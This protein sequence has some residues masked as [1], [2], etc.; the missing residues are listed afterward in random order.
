MRNSTL[1]RTLL[2]LSLVQMAAVATLGSRVA[3]A[4]P[5]VLP[6]PLIIETGVRAKQ[7]PSNS[8][9]LENYG[10]GCL[11]PAMLAKAYNL[12][13]LHGSG[14]DGTGRTIVIVDSF[15]S[16]TIENDLHVFDQTFG[17]PDPPSLTIIQPS[18]PVPPFDPTNST[19]LG[20]AGETTLDV[21]YAHAFAPGAAIILVETPVAETEGVMGFPEM[22]HAE[23]YVLDHDLGDVITQSFGATEQTFP[24]KEA[25]YELRSAYKKAA[26]RKVSVLAG[27][28]DEGATNDEPNGVDLY[29][30]RAIGWPASDPL[31]TAVGGTSLTLDDSGNRLAPDSV[32]NDVFGASGGG[33]SAVFHRPD[34]QDGVRD[35]VGHARGIPD[36]SL[37]AACV[38]AAVWT[39]SSYPP[40]GPGFGLVCGTSEASPEFAGIVAM[41]D[42]QAGRRLGLLGPK[43][44]RLRKNSIVDITSGNNTLGPFTNTNGQTYTVIG[45]DAGPGYDLASGLGT[46]DAEKFVHALARGDDGDDG[47][48]D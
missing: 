21:E 36:I 48:E 29:P 35:V 19:M 12:N 1:G 26:E 10:L 24:N 4:G 43:L 7:L 15:G 46:L 34:F 11:T 41:A 33:V 32:W 6:R 17:L 23:N 18:G 3:G 40:Y 14:I 25:I 2:A 38:N 44:Y 30:Y 9:C 13:P 20:W 8:Y 5:A 28:G 31:V 22:I 47:G 45:Y 16:P 27:S 37:S 39:Y 42:Q